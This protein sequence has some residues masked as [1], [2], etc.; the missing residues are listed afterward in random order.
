MR[1]LGF[2]REKYPASEPPHP[3][4]LRS[5]D[6]SP[7]GRGEIEKRGDVFIVA[8]QVRREMAPTD[9]AGPAGRRASAGACAPERWP[10]WS[11]RTVP[12][13]SLAGTATTENVRLPI[14]PQGS[15]HLFA[16]AGDAERLVV[17]HGE[18]VQFLRLSCSKNA[19]IGTMQRRSKQASANM[20]RR[21]MGSG[22]G[23]DQP[24][25][26]RCLSSNGGR[27]PS[28]AWPRL[29]PGRSPD[30]RRQH[31]SRSTVSGIPSV[32]IAASMRASDTNGASLEMNRDKAAHVHSRPA[33]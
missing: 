22:A 24:K 31:R 17:C 6:L 14:A 16:D 15:R 33:A 26:R 5:L 1:G 9:R 27:G 13:S 11:P 3:C 19:S 25:F 8:I 20:R 32:K 21:S 28:A 2:V 18:G 29:L 7:L 23:I 30:G 12:I 4:S 10:A